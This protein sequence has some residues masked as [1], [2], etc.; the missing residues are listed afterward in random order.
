MV[1]RDARAF[2]SVAEVYDRARPDYPDPALDWLRRTLD[3]REGRTVLDLAA[4]TG[5]LTIGL[6]RT[7]ARVVAVEPS[8]GML[9]RLRAALPDVEALEGTAEAIPLPDA[10]VDAVAVGQAFHWFATEEA[11]AEMQ[12]VLKPSGRLALVWNRRD[13]DDPAQRAL[14]GVL[15]RWERG[16][17]RQRHGTWRD[18]MEATERFEPLATFEL[19]HEQR[20]SFEA[21]VER[22]LSTSFIAALPGGERAVVA[23]EVRRATAEFGE[24]VVLPYVAELFAYVRR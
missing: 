3:L 11:L 15:D 10:S 21:V 9:A 18:A 13:L 16:T 20:L 17:P 24:P 23:D 6:A 2:G 4:G 19:R 5:K 7:R 12:R 1:H 22:V 14:D 8:E